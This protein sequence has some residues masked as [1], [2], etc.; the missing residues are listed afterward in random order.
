MEKLQE[1]RRFVNEAP[2][3]DLLKALRKAGY[4]GK[5]GVKSSISF[6]QDESKTIH[7]TEQVNHKKSIINGKKSNK[8]MEMDLTLEAIA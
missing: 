7:Y 3:E 6:S 5:E 1:F 8:Y 2:I 4:T